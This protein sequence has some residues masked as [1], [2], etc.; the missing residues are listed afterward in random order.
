MLVLRLVSCFPQINGKIFGTIFE[1][2]RFTH[3]ASCFGWMYQL[4]QL[5]CMHLKQLVQSAIKCPCVLTRLVARSGP[6]LC[7]IMNCSPP[8]SSVHEISQVRILE[9]IAISFSRGSSG[10]TDWNSLSC[11]S[12]G[13][14]TC[15]A[16]SKVPR[17]LIYFRTDICVMQALY[18]KITDLFIF[19]I[20][21]IIF[22]SIILIKDCQLTILCK[23]WATSKIFFEISIFYIVLIL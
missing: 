3:L 8:G 2:S 19:F 7:N 10:T 1:T 18:Y 23:L 20:S 22:D 4:L 6:T 13:F 5:K 21:I 17:L 16:I 14:F 9:Q 12:G 15:W 11:I